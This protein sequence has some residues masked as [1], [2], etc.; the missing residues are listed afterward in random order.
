MKSI[1]MVDLKG[2][3]EKIKPEVDSAI[4]QVIDN[5]AFIGG[6]AVSEFQSNLEKY[7]DVNHVIPCANG[8]DALQLALMS[9]ELSPGDE[10]ITTDFTFAATVEVIGLLGLKPVLIDINTDDYNMDIDALEKAIS[11][12]TKGLYLYIFWT[13][14]YRHYEYRFKRNLYVIEDTAQALGAHYA[15]RRNRNLNHWPYWNHFLFS[16]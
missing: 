11:P 10:V 16:K 5:T 1:Q 9:L 4:Q 3:Y 6:A 12:N 8:T 15:T 13:N 7:L 14:L 2:Q